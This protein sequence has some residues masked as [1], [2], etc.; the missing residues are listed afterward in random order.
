MELT[1]GKAF[2]QRQ[3]AALEAGDKDT[4]LTQYHPDAAIVGLDFAVKGHEPI[5]KHLEGYLEHLGALKVQSTDKFIEIED[6]I[7]FEATITTNLGE[8]R[9]YNVFLLRD[10]K[11]T[12][13]FT[14]LI[15]LNPL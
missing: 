14:G 1:P 9:V 4:L 5:G 15:S 2:Y 3:I 8:A 7:F 6:A 12:H 10:E 13:H 11:A